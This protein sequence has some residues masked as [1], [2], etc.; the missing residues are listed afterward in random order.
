ML[1]PSHLRAQIWEFGWIPR[2]QLGYKSYH[3]AVVEAIDPPGMVLTCPCQT[4]ARCLIT[5]HMLW[6]G[7]WIH[8]HAELPPNLWAQIWEFSWNHGSLLGNTSY[9]NAV[10]EALN[11]PVMVPTSMSNICKVFD[12]LHILWMGR[13][14]HHHA[15]LP[16]NLW[17]QIWEFSW[18]HGSLLGNTS[19]H[20]AVVEALNPPVTVPTSMSNICKVFDNLHILWMGRWIHHHAVVTTFVGPD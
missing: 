2:S 9:H 14:I 15:E 1:L 3:N 6:M 12:N 11:P 5:L 20:N 18:N 8:H 19:Y 16:P 7:R 13:W 17:A 10:V 4:Y